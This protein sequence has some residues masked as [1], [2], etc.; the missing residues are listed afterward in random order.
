MFIFFRNMFM[1]FKNVFM[2]FKSVLVLTISLMRG[3]FLCIAFRFL[4]CLAEKH[5]SSDLTPGKTG[6]KFI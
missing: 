4:F 1:F 3:S 2:F 6:I 5:R